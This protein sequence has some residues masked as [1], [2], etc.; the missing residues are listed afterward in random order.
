VFG[1]GEQSRDFTFVDD[2]VAANLQAARAPEAAGSFMNLGCGDR[3]TLNRLLELLQR[4]LQ[5]E[6]DPQYCDERPGDV[7]H[8]QADI[9]KARRLIGYDPQVSFEEGLR[10]T[11]EH[12]RRQS[13]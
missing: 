11:V 9:A 1:D 3:H 10:R 6:A 13:G 2:V 4:I 7:K 12:Y 8:S 5:V